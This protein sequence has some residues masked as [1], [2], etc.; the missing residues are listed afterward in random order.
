MKQQIN[1]RTDLQ[2]KR[3]RQQTPEVRAVSGV[4]WK[5]LFGSAEAALLRTAA[6]FV[7]AD[8]VWAGTGAACATEKPVRTAAVLAGALSVPALTLL[9]HSSLVDSRCLASSTRQVD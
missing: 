5:T 2:G 9:K 4:L 3:A 1:P 7:S 8:K 6:C